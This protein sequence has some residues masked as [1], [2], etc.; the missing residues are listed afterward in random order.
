MRIEATVPFF[1]AFCPFGKTSDEEDEGFAIGVFEEKT[2]NCQLLT[3]HQSAFLLAKIT[4]KK[5]SMTDEAICSSV[6][7]Q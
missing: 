1:G 6:I 4:L 2:P 5:P 3:I 7:S